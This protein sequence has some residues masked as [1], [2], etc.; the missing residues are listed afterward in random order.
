MANRRWGTP[1]TDP[2]VE[3]LLALIAVPLALLAGWLIFVLAY[4]GGSY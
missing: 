1:K 4:V 3:V 2:V